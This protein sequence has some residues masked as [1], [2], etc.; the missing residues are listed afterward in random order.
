MEANES[1][2]Y[3]KLAPL[4]DVLMGDVDYESWADFIDEIMQTHHREPVDV[5]EIA[6]GTGSVIVSLGELECYNLTG[7]DL[8]PAMIE[9]AKQKAI[10][11]DVHIDFEA[12]SFLELDYVNQFDCV[13]SVF[14]SVNYLH[15]PEE[16]LQM[17]ENVARALKPG[18]LYIFDFSTPKNSLQAVDHLNEA[19]GER[20][21]FRFFRK[22]H[23]HPHTRIHYNEFEIDEL[24]PS[25]KK[26]IHTWKETHKQRAY[27]LKEML[28]I[29]EQTSYH[30]L[31]KYDGFDLIE[32]TDN[33]ARVTMVLQWQKTQ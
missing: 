12:K 19:E 20:G 28:S 13:Y 6:C 22:S 7:T 10:D 4:Y 18:G 21:N 30:Q 16:M 17:F 27:T 8:S 25:T 23:Y 2:I 5:M 1:S 15:T 14:D 24:D 33:S 3:T 31:A 26:V 9:V 11:Y 29:L 32:A